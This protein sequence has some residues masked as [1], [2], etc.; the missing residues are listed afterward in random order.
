[1]TPSEFIPY[2]EARIKYQEDENTKQNDRIGLLAAILQNGIPTG[3]P[4]KNAK[5]RHPKDY[6]AKPE[7]KAS[8]KP[9]EQAYEEA[10]NIMKAWCG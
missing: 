7:P 8:E 2:I 4:K 5:V 6:F 10:F 9:K 3:Q 1:M